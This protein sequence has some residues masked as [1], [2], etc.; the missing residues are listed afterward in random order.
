MSDTPSATVAPS[1]AV[2]GAARYAKYIFWLMFIINFLNYLDRW[3]FTGL[4][5]IIQLDL[6]I[7]NTQIGLLAT[8]FLLVYA[9]VAM[10]LGF[11]ADR[12]ARKGI[13]G[14][15]VAVWSVATVLTGFA[16]N[17]LTLF[18]I[19]ALLGIGEGSYYPAGTPMLA[20]QFPPK[21]RASVLARWSTGALIGAA[22]GFL[23]A[24]FFDQST[25]RYAFFFT[26]VPGLIFAFLI[27]RTHEKTRHEDDPPAR[28]ESAAHPSIA[29]RLR[30]YLSIPT[31]RVI[32][33]M[34]ALG[35]LGIYGVT[36]FLTI[37]LADTYGTV[38]VHRDKFNR[39][40]G[41]QPGPFPHAGLTQHLLPILAGGV[42]IVGG[43]L[44]NLFGGYLANRLSRRH[45]G[46]RVMAGGLGFLL[47]AP[48]VLVAVGA[49][50]V[51]PHL[52]LYQ[53]QTE[54][55]QVL[56][57][58]TIFTIFGLLTAFFLNVYNGPV[59]AATLDVVAAAER[60]A[61]GGT[62]L[63]LSHLLGDVYAGVAIG[64]LADFMAGRLGSEGFGLGAAIL[65]VVPAT[66]ILSGVVGIW[67]SRFYQRDIEKL[68]ATTEGML[69]TV[70][71]HV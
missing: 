17:F 7:D 41:T 16:S 1:P 11:S 56:I 52:A 42:I 34:Q 15:G 28:A 38:V 54:A 49:P 21:S 13:V 62:V 58:V 63:S 65:L 60:G 24:S 27:W 25:W 57:G 37:Y 19:R 44:G 55:N 2:R 46:A 29:A 6:K 48:C 68:G 50:F 9:L 14:L 32:I 23:L 18:G 43:I 66:L 30:T 70:A 3:V 67:G 4:S 36:T 71:M 31:M 47:A 35:F 40:I 33:A 64:A 12:V 61:A 20:A 22:V 51:L 45:T 10:P 53:T 39:I 59:S 5:D 69:G 26:G 8:A